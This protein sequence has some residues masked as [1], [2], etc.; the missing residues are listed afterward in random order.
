MPQNTKSNRYI[1]TIAFAIA[2]LILVNGGFAYWQM[3]QIKTE[4]EDVAQ[5]DLPLVTQLLPLIDR[6]FEQTLLIE[7]LHQQSGAHQTAVIKTLADSFIR[8]GNKFD[9]TL[10]ALKTF[11][12][13]MMSFGQAETRAE[14]TRVNNL[15]NQIGS[16]HKEYHDQVIGMIEALKV[17]GSELPEQVIRLLNEEEQDLRKELTN[18]RDEVQRFTQQSVLAVEKHESWAIQGI[19]LFTLFVYSLGAL[20]LFMIYQVMQHRGK[21]IAE[22]AYFAT[23]DPLTKL[24][25]RRYF[26]ERLDEAINSAGRHKHPLS[27]CICDL[28]HFKQINDT[29]GHQAGDKVLASF[30]EILN[31]VKRPEDIAGRF[32]G[33]EFVLCFPNTHAKDSL[34]MIERI[35]ETMADKKFNT[36]KST[37]FSVTATFGVAE[38]DLNNL[39]QESLFEVAD[40]A[41]Y[42]AKEKG[43]NQVICL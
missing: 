16:E 37:P 17:D 7:K 11:I 20:M 33:D 26:F 23:H 8:T 24:S 1:F 35:R 32:G 29:L 2:T 41:L 42:Q 27:I 14:M 9:V 34:A 18:L 30:A 25:N 13:P 10:S 36:G 21:A 5:R 12:L 43:R 4:F 19:V 15:L 40:K 3:H 31:E 38:L 22:L 6:Q 39:C 28:D